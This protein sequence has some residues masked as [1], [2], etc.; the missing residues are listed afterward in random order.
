MPDC[1]R[2]WYDF[3]QSGEGSL[4]QASLH[5]IKAPSI[6][7]GFYV[8]LIRA[9][10]RQGAADGA[11]GIADSGSQETHDSNHDDSDEGEDDRILNEALAFF[12]G[13]K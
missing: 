10:L 7:R 5:N 13:C 12:F 8:V 2:R 6:R 1:D 11:E 3:E 9:M 4:C